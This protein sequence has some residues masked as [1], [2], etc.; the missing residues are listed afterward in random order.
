MTA[1]KSEFEATLKLQYKLRLGVDIFT[2]HTRAGTHSEGLGLGFL[3]RWVLPCRSGRVR[4]KVERLKI[5][6]ACHC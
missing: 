4:V 3:D 2:I 5:S 6:I 1:A